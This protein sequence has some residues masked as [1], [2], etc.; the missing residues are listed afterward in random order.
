MYHGAELFGGRSA[1]MQ[2]FRASMIECL[3][4]QLAD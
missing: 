2:D 1:V 4:T 3:R